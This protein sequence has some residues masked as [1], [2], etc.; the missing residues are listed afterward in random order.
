MAWKWDYVS[1]ISRRD[2]KTF[3]FYGGSRS[4]VT[5]QEPTLMRIKVCFFIIRESQSW[6]ILCVD[7]CRHSHV[8]KYYI[9]TH[10]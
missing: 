6:S 10:L 1:L 9:I 5:I 8:P 3:I 4:E 7:G 2:K